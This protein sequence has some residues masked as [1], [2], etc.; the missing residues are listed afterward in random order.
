MRPTLPM[1]AF[2]LA[3]TCLPNGVQ[4]QA[5]QPL[6]PGVYFMWSPPGPLTTTPDHPI[7]PNFD[8]VAQQTGRATVYGLTPPG[9]V[10][11]SAERPAARRMGRIEAPFLFGH[12]WYRLASSGPAARAPDLWAGGADYAAAGQP[13]ALWLPNEGIAMGDNVFVSV[14]VDLAHPPAAET[15]PVYAT[16]TGALPPGGFGSKVRV[17]LGALPAGEYRVTIEARDPGANLQSVSTRK[18]IVR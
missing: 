8:W 9:P 10:S 6:A 7:G 16:T 4:A 15:P 13:I 1:A 12:L 3:A 18:L 14:R 11:A 2:L 5:T 17:D